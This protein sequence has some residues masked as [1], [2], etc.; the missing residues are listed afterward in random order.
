ITLRIR[1][2]LGK[3]ASMNERIGEAVQSP[4]ELNR[5]MEDLLLSCERAGEGGKAIVLKLS[6]GDAS[7][8]LQPALDALKIE[9]SERSDH[10]IKLFKLYSPRKGAWEYK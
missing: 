2:I 8:D 4:E 1:S 6:V 3:L 5:T 9:S 7:P 10:A